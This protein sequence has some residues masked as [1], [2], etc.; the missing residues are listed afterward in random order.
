V[1]L[2]W[3][4]CDAVECMDE[5]NMMVVMHTDLCRALTTPS[6]TCMPALTQIL[7]VN[8]VSNLNYV[9][10]LICKRQDNIMINCQ[11]THFGVQNIRM[12]P[13][14][15]AHARTNFHVSRF[16]HWNQQNDDMLQNEYTNCFS[17]RYVINNSNLCTYC[18]DDRRVNTMSLS[19]SNSYIVISY[20]GWM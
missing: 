17:R 19:E 13:M 14:T 3:T 5:S 15:L 4:Q 6:M 11:S 16:V 1:H 10:S 8:F 7:L 20:G 2:V 9:F 18:K 12:A